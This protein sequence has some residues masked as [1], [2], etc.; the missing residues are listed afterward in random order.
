MCV[1]LSCNVVW[2]RKGNDI[3]DLSIRKIKY[4][5]TET[6]CYDPLHR[7]WEIFSIFPNRKLVMCRRKTNVNSWMKHF[8]FFWN[9]FWV[10]YWSGS[11]S[12]SVD[13]FHI[14]IIFFHRLHWHLN[15]YICIWWIHH[16]SLVHSYFSHWFH[17]L[18]SSIRK[19]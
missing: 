10:N 8:F 18:Y 16:D 4:I 6:K 19:K 5:S 7:K 9:S 14:I 12:R 13:S 1:K 17:S 3:I 15:S 11:K 2:S